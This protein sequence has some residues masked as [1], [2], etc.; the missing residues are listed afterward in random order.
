MQ[1][2]IINDKPSVFLT[3]VTPVPVTNPTADY[4]TAF[5]SIATAIAAEAEAQQHTNCE[6]CQAEMVSWRTANPT[7][8]E[9]DAADAHRNIW[10]ACP[11]CRAEYAQW[12]EAVKA[13]ADAEAEFEAHLCSQYDAEAAELESLG[14]GARHYIAGHDLVGRAGGKI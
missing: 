2:A 1:T 11:S 5:V 4:A 10:E 7:A 12:S 14:D 6:L 13:D 9:A 3:P 8:S